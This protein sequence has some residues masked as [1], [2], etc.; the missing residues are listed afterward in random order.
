WQS[1]PVRYPTTAYHGNSW[2]L[3]FTPGPVHPS[4]ANLNA[5]DSSSA[6]ILMAS[7]VRTFRQHGWSIYTVI[8][9][10]RPS[11]NP[12]SQKRDYRSCQPSSRSNRF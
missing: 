9:S 1:T 7:L 5:G 2:L 8:P 11:H 3:V 12:T 4:L 10:L 6:P